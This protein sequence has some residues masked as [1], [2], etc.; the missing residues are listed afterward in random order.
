[1]RFV[2]LLKAFPHL[3]NLL[4]KESRIHL[5]SCVFC[6]G[7][8]LVVGTWVGKVVRLVSQLFTALLLRKGRLP[9]FQVRLPLVFFVL[10]ICLIIF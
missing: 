3:I 4:P 6:S 9:S 10:V 5:F 8:S 7:R 2:F 1:M